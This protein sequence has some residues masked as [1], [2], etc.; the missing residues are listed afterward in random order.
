MIPSSNPSTD[1]SD[2]SFKKA[3]QLSIAAH[4]VLFVVLFLKTLILPS[5]PD[6]KEYLPSLKVDLVALP[7]QKAAEVTTPAPAPAA[8][9]EIKAPEKPAEPVSEKTSEKL[10]DKKAEKTK[11]TPGDYSLKKKKSKELAKEQARERMQSALARIK[12][13]EKIRAGEQ[14]KGNKI[15]TGSSAKGVLNENAETVYNDIVRDRISAEWEL[16]QWL[17]DQN[18]TAKVLIRIDR[19]GVISLVRFIRTSGNAQFDTAVKRTLLAAS[20]IPPPPISVLPSVSQEG[21]VLGFPMVD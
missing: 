19:R 4:I 16:P 17:Q 18:L 10:A 5:S 3:I 6:V 9:E 15:M 14:I 8:P 1:R 12:A 21:I 13:L 20:P 2:E 7:D 11:E